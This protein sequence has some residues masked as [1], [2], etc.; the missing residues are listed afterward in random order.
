MNEQHIYIK[1]LSLKK[2]DK[3]IMIDIE[4]K[5]FKEG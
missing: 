2:R 1:N 5:N 3:A 4:K